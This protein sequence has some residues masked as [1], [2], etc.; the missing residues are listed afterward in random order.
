MTVMEAGIVASGRELEIRHRSFSG[1]FQL[2]AWPGQLQAAMDVMQAHGISL[3]DRIGGVCEGAGTVTMAIAPGR[4][5]IETGDGSI[6]ALAPETGV[7]TDLSHARE[8]FA[9]SGA[10]APQLAS[11]IAPVDFD[12]PR[13][14]PGSVIQTGS[15]HSIPFTLWRRA[16]GGFVLYV[17]GSYARDFAHSL[18]AEAEEF[19]GSA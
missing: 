1:L 2:S 7:V 14:G 19:L 4:W 9:L 17:E 18:A 8:S 11:K 12:L 5:L 16:D 6:P 15:G 3:S 10:L 13:H